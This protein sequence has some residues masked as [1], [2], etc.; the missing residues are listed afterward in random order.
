MRTIRPISRFRAVSPLFVAN[1]IVLLALIYSL[2]LHAGELASA[3]PATATQD[4]SYGVHGMALFGGKDALFASHLPMFHAPH[5]QQ[6]ILQ[7]EILDPAIQHSVRMEL[8]RQPELWTLNPEPFALNALWQN[9]TPLRE[10]DAQLF[11]GH[12]ERGGSSRFK[13]VKVRVVRV[14][15]HAPLA[16]NAKARMG[17]ATY[18]AIHAGTTS[19]LFKHITARPDF[20]HIVKLAN[21]L[22]TD[23]LQ[24]TS[25][26]DLTASDAALKQALGAQYVRSIYL[27]DADLK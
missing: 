22:A 14:V 12:F 10:F 23:T 9:D 27:D 24:I 7:I 4:A 21:T 15:F 6:V 5:N 18:Q 2:T 17:A 11:Q 16:A 26:A 19:F 3:K 1:L 8:E 25:T 20:D 13:G